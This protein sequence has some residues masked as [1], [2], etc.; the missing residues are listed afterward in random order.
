ML[1][2]HALAAF[3]RSAGR[4]MSTNIANSRRTFFRRALY[5]AAGA[6]A[7][8]GALG[9]GPRETATEPPAPPAIAPAAPQPAPP[10]SDRS[11]LVVARRAGARLSDTSL[12]RRAAQELLDHAL[13]QLTGES[14]VARAWSR[15]FA[16]D[17]VVAIKVNT[18][19]R[20]VLSTPPV[21]VGVVA[22]RLQGIGIP[23][24]NIIVWDRSASELREAGYTLNDG[25]TG[26]QYVTH[27][28]EWDQPTSSGQWRGRLPK[29]LT[30]R[31]SALINMPVLKDH[32]GAGITLSMKNHYGTI[33]NPGN[34]HA[35]GCDPYPADISA[36]PVIRQKQRLIIADATRACWDQ[37][38]G[39]NDVGRVVW[40]YNGILVGTDPVA[41]D[42]QG[43][44]IIEQQRQSVGV[45]ALAA[46]GRRPKHIQS[47]ADR[48]VGTN[49]PSRM[50]VLDTDIV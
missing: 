33:D 35:N 38:P 21:L 2:Y 19:A 11:R 6:A 31:C 43:W 7:I 4:L 18:I 12:D 15:Y 5:G 28:G 37:G 16:A 14:D 45:P 49:D 34:C 24:S 23:A 10:T 48:G 3:G 17:D 40:N 44:Q 42:Y 22:D 13:Q 46:I 50:D 30:Q 41:V 47:A 27:K 9:C 26:V 29:L 36:H 32:G 39:P 25:G 8:G 20:A 1:V